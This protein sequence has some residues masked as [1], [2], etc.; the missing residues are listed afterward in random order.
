MHPKPIDIRKA[1]ADCGGN[2]DLNTRD[3][4]LEYEVAADAM[5]EV[6]TSVEYLMVELRDALNTL[7]DGAPTHENAV[8]TINA[9]TDV[10]V[11]IKHREFIAKALSAARSHLVAAY[12]NRILPSIP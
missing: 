11:G 8:K 6:E 9:A 5:C 7:D 10:N 2:V 1:A 4:W 12:G 3:A